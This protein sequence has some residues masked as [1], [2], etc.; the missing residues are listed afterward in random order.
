MI[1]FWVKMLAWFSQQSL[2]KKEYYKVLKL[3][4]LGLD[5]FVISSLSC[6]YL[7]RCKKKTPLIA[8]SAL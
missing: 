5:V 2:V 4:Q 1:Y 6:F 7:T 8:Y 3:L